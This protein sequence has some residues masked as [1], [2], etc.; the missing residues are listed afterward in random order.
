MDMGFS[1]LNSEYDLTN[2]GTIQDMFIRSGLISIGIII[3]KVI[4]IYIVARLA[5]YVATKIIARA[6]K[7][8]SGKM[9][10]RKEKTL[11][12]I[13]INITKYAVYF[14]AACQILSLFGVDMTSILAVAGIG[15]VAIGFAAQGLVKD[16]IT[17]AFILLEDQ[18]G[19]GDLVT[20]NGFTGVVEEIGM[21]TTRIR[22]ADGNVYIIPNSAITVVTNSSR[23]YNCAM[24]DFQFA[25]GQDIDKV[26]AIADTA[27]EEMLKTITGL[28]EKPQIGAVNE[29][30]PWVVS[31][32]LVA[33]CDVG[34]KLPAEKEMRLALKRCF[35]KEGIK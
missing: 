12:S 20:V 28:K 32:K 34:A 13:I 10:E 26:M 23:D 21:R 35:D 15:S 3:L 29:I 7:L 33:R 22:A 16:F 17:G 11:S 8:H 9:S 5:I 1:I 18:Y 6:V 31:M 27:A 2:P 24:V 30:S 14:L 25:A 4:V 19:V